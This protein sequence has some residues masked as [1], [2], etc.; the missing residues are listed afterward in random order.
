MLLDN[1]QAH[2][3]SPQGHTV[4]SFAARNGVDKSVLASSANAVNPSCERG[5][6]ESSIIIRILIPRL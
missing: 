4:H 5:N 6:E 1:R 2:C 3:F